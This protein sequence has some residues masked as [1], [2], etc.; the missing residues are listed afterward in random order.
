MS[1]V[2][3]TQFLTYL[4]ALLANWP[5]FCLIVGLVDLIV[6]LAIGGAELIG[7]EVAIGFLKYFLWK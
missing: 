5:C 7:G 4:L 1:Q 3:K 2:S 6:G